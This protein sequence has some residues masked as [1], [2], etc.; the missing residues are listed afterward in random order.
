MK[1]GKIKIIA[2]IKEAF[3]DVDLDD[4]IGLSEADALDSY[5]DGKLRRECRQNDEKNDWR[6][7]SSADLNKYNSSLS[8]F[9]AKGMQFHLPAFLIADINGQYMY[10][11]SFV[12][13]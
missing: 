12:L 10:G 8:Y 5:A 1:K 11:M 2:E 7:I 3:K 4:G 9:D 6:V 13:T